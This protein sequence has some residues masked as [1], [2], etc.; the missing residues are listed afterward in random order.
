MAN[1]STIQTPPKKPVAPAPEG[2]IVKQQNVGLAN[3]E[4]I[5]DYLQGSR[6]KGLEDMG[7]RDL[8]LPRIA[9][10]QTLS[11]ALNKK[12]PQFIPDLEEGMLYNTITREV[13]GTKLKVVPIIF[14]K[15]RILFE[16]INKGGGILCQSV[17][18]INGGK[19]CPAGCL[20]CSKSAFTDGEAPE[21]NEFFNYPSMLPEHGGTIAVVSMKSKSIKV[22]KKW[23]SLMRMSG[24]AAYAIAW[25]ISV[26]QDR[27]GENDFW[28]FEV[29][30]V[31]W[32]PKEIYL[33][34]E[35]YYE[36]LR[37]QGIK[38]DTSDLGAEQ[39][40]EFNTAEM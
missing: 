13:Y 10:A 32:A 3:R 18:G 26:V 31:G 15:A 17:N 25:E 20:S 14:G 21:C 34:G 24:V 33:V 29:E 6:G 16:D 28:N 11:P 5:P 12:K 7:Q 4:Q 8:T 30:R 23:N 38:V 1:R 36:N 9:I 27:Q 39:T 19:L 37:A 35:Q 40:T 2:K 22:A